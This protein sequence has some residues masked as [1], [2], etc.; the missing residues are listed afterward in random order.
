M[1]LQICGPKL[2]SP[3]KGNVHYEMKGVNIIVLVIATSD[4]SYLSTDNKTGTSQ[5]LGQVNHTL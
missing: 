4:L 3:Y 1:D 2:D 5:W